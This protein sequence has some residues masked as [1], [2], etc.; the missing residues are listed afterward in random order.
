MLTLVLLLKAVY[1]NLLQ[2]ITEISLMFC[3]VSSAPFSG[4]MVIAETLGDKK[5]STK[6]MKVKDKSKK[7]K[8]VFKR[9]D[10]PHDSITHHVSTTRTDF[11]ST[12]SSREEVLAMASGDYVL[13]KRTPPISTE[14]QLELKVE[15]SETSEGGDGTPTHVGTVD[16]VKPFDISLIDPH[17]AI[18]DR[19]FLAGHKVNGSMKSAGGAGPTCTSLADGFE[20]YLQREGRG[21]VFSGQDG[22][23]ELSSGARS[24]EP[25]KLSVEHHRE[26]DHVLGVGVPPL[27]IDGVVKKAKKD[28]TVKKLKKDRVVMKTKVLK[29]RKEDLNLEKSITGEK[30]KKKKKESGGLE[31]NL[32]HP[33]KRLKTV[34]QGESARK[35]AG[36]SIGIGLVSKDYSQVEAVRKEIAASGIHS[37]SESS[38]SLS[39]FDL[40]NIEL[41][42]LVNDLLALASDPFHGADRNSAAIVRHVLLRFRSLVYQKSLVIIPPS[43]ADTSEI[44][45]GKSPLRSEELSDFPLK[46]NTHLTRPDDPTRSGRKRGHSDRQEEKSAKRTKKVNEIKSMAAEKKK[47]IEV[48]QAEPKKIN[49]QPSFLKKLESSKVVDDPAMLVMKFPPRVALPSIQELKARFGR[50]GP[51]DHSATRAF[52]K[53]STCRVVFRHLSDARVA[54]QY[55]MR[56]DGLFGNV[57]VNYQVKEVGGPEVSENTK[58]TDARALPKSTSLQQQPHQRAGQLKSC[59]KKPAGEEARPK[60]GITKETPRVKFMLGGEKTVSSNNNNNNNNNMDFNNGGSS[61]SSF[62]MDVNNSKN[63]RKVIPSSLPAL[64]PLPPGITPRNLD[65]RSHGAGQSSPFS[66]LNTHYN[67]VLEPRNNNSNLSTTVASPSVTASVAHVD[68]SHKMLSLLI[69]CNDIVSNVQRSLGYASYQP[70]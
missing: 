47:I 53:S 12:S 8:Y 30:R 59:L 39:S 23:A 66:K 35:F 33:N 10:E 32:E 25:A 62:A 27:P 64:L 6:Q 19:S 50:F 49:K 15:G 57:K 56:S 58:S 14:V 5:S 41:P 70:L 42:Q 11:G 24:M 17:A 52:W 34:K 40:G 60:V 18:P 45:V 36:K 37:L 22:N 13:Q 21:M 4:R 54:Y 29:Q 63:I 43:E 69:R 9:R 26:Q 28:R 51:L 1:F 68:I 2:N 44:S 46:P 31:S 48:Q 61:S 20:E 7:D 38:P 67:E 55:A 16:E 3:T 65:S